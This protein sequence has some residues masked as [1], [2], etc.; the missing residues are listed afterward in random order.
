MSK[1]AKSIVFALVL[2]LVCSLLLTAA[3]SGLRSYH[4]KNI[5][6]DMHKN[7][8]KSVGLIDDDMRLTA[9]EIETLYQE[10]IR[11][12]WVDET[13]MIISE[14]DRTPQS[15]PIYLFI[16]KSDIESYI[17]PIES[18][19]LWGKIYGY[20]AVADDGSTV[21]GFT[22]YQH[23]ETPGL[24]GEIEKRW[25]QKNFEGK[26]ITDHQGGL[27]SVSVAK[28]AVK[29]IPSSDQQAHYVDGISGATLTGKFLT[30][31][32]KD[33]L[34]QYEPVSVRFRKNEL[35]IDSLK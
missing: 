29:D 14:K 9:A 30:S 32:I 16:R 34:T 12:V 7:I 4:Q 20:L 18:R 27:V 33:V 21:R 3:S 25:F 6:T 26:Q 19:G 31:G 17:I 2:C 13:G 28:G 23:S 11:S 1:N 22:V 10:T 24:G 35:T 8:L 15:L 5:A